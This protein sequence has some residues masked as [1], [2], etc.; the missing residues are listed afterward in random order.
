MAV[1]GSNQGRDR[2]GKGG[3]RGK[4][5]SPGDRGGSRSPPHTLRMKGPGSPTPTGHLGLPHTLLPRL[6]ADGGSHGGTHPA[7]RFLLFGN[8][9][10][11][12]LESMACHQCRWQT[13]CGDP[14]HRP[15]PDPWARMDPSDLW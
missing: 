8:L 6:Q 7:V 5:K 13:V 10:G 15:C 9:Q 14:D 3:R 12:F 4:G 2:A 11:S 1:E